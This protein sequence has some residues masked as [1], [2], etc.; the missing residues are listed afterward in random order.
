MPGQN[1]AGRSLGHNTQEYRWE[2]RT[3]ATPVRIQ[4]PEVTADKDKPSRRARWGEGGQRRWQ[5]QGGLAP[6]QRVRWTA[7]QRRVAMQPVTGSLNAKDRRHAPPRPL[8]TSPALLPMA[9]RHDRPSLIVAKPPKETA[10]TLAL[11]V[12]IEWGMQ[13]WASLSICDRRV[14]SPRAWER[15]WGGQKE[16]RNGRLDGSAARL[17]RFELPTLLQNAATARI[18]NWRTRPLSRDGLDFL[19]PGPLASGGG[20]EG[21]SP[22]GT[23]ASR[24]VPA[25]VGAENPG[26]PLTVS[27]SASNPI[28]CLLRWVSPSSFCTF[29]ATSSAEHSTPRSAVA[30]WS[31]SATDNLAELLARLALAMALGVF[32]GTS[33]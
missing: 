24:Q 5:S 32:S 10:Q 14:F 1:M 22:E 6:E 17:P 16:A 31:T 12:N 15:G 9:E 8:A 2:L 27:R 7:S 20:E 30:F 21:N 29:D 33:A 4:R 3:R 18:P 19:G 11:P 23:Q 28:P 13:I 26:R 25:H